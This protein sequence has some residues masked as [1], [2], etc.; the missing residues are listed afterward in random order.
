MIYSFREHHPRPGS[1]FPFTSSWG[2]RGGEGWKDGEGTR[3]G[4][5]THGE[6]ETRGEGER[7]R[8]GLGKLLDLRNIGLRS[9]GKENL[10]NP[11][12]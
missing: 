12:S 11:W 3:G 2:S 10:V 5:E 8:E 9:V 6:G 7:N 4:A 1:F